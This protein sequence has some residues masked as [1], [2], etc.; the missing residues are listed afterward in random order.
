[1]FIKKIEDYILYE[2][3]DILVCRK[4][5]GIAVQN[6]RI[7]TM[8]LESCLKNY[9]AEK[10][11]KRPPYLA[12]VHRLDQPVEGVLVFGKNPKAA[13][14]LSAQITAGKMEKIYLAVTYGQPKTAAVTQKNG[15]FKASEILED[16]LKKDGKTNTSSVV[17]ASV[18][19][20]KKARLSYEM[21]EEITE[22]ISEKKKYLLRIHLET[23]RHHQIRV[24]MAHAG[25]P[26]A[27][28]R[29][30]GASSQAFVGN[31]GLALCAASLTFCH[32]VTGK[33]MKYEPLP[34][35]PAFQGFL[36]LKR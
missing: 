16:Y 23:G 33:V 15:V 8:D 13:K 14:E 5:A 29:K 24:Q 17:P 21:L 10:E 18:P 35:S 20:A 9:L 2:D 11:G 4:P 19:G 28:D 32:P 3:K 22:P 25:M 27:G 26:L 1:M 34:E 7:G 30:Y 36:T 31:G 12:V 6:A